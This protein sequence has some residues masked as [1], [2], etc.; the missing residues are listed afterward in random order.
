MT[1]PSSNGRG[2]PGR[3][4]TY[5]D[6]ALVSSLSVGTI[7]LGSV[8]D[9]ASTLG[10]VRIALGV[11]FVF[12]VPGYALT[13]LLFPAARPDG[14][15]G[16]A[17]GRGGLVSP[18]EMVVLSVGLSIATVPLVGLLLSATEWGVGQ[19]TVLGALTL[20]VVLAVVVAAIR[21]SRLAAGER[22]SVDYGAL[23]DRLAA[24]T[25][26]RSGGPSSTLNLF[27]AVALLVSMGLTGAALAG[28]PDGERY[29]EFYL[30][31][32]NDAGEL[33]A[34]DYPRTLSVDEPTTLYVGIGNH[35]GQPTDYT[36]LVLL[37][38]VEPTGGNDSVTESVVIDRY[39]TRVEPGDREVEARSLRA[40]PSLTGERLR[41][42]FLLYAGPP[43]AEQTIE[44]AYSTTHIWVEVPSS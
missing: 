34:D 14:N 30:L 20:F 22:F 19:G 41:L 11:L 21:R 4:G 5:L 27:V 23:A 29:T 9:G 36:V 33:V 38:A 13:A 44:T 6:L 25:T 42:T 28:A 10:P 31:S 35:E 12:F 2:Q 32:A 16:A 43:P 7:L 8:V 24:I 40:D 17:D 26:L 37:Q 3:V 18:F 1:S 39:E 15:P